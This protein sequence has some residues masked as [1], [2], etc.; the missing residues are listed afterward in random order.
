MKLSLSGVYSRIIPLPA[1]RAHGASASNDT[2]KAFQCWENQSMPIQEGHNFILFYTIYNRFPFFSPLLLIQID[3]PVHLHPTQR[4][5]YSYVVIVVVLVWLLKT[6]RAI[7][8]RLQ[9]LPSPCHGKNWRLTGIQLH[10]DIYNKFSL[11]LP[12]FGIQESI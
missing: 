2:V 8:I 7:C 6:E 12:L 1:L 5:I 11:S 9:L 3:Y 4:N 10:V